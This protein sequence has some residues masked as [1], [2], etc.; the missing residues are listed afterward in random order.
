MTFHSSRFWSAFD[1]ANML[2]DCTFFQKG[3]NVP[4]TVK[5]RWSEPD[6][7]DEFRGTQSKQYE[8]EYRVADMP[9]LQEGD[10]LSI[11]ESDTCST[12]YRVRVAPYVDENGGA[13]GVYKRAI[14]TRE[15][16]R[17]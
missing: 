17:D 11:A 2:V 9:D 8:I 6:R 1:R 13:D 7:I 5:V 16:A 10:P 14:L 12:D 15:V 4:K 3:G